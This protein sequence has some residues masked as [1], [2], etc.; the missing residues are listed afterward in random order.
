MTGQAS[1]RHRSP[2]GG[3]AA[4]DLLGTG[5]QSPGVTKGTGWWTS[6]AGQS[7]AAPP[8][9]T[10]TGT[11]RLWH[12]FVTTRRQCPDQDSTGMVRF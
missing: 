9:E 8:V 10:W 4:A 2:S 3:R 7:A 6:C 11:L 5:C 12:R 1:P